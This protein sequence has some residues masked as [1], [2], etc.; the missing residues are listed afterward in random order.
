M[1]RLLL[2]LSIVIL[3]GQS[4][5]SG[6]EYDDKFECVLFQDGDQ[7][8]QL[9]ALPNRQGIDVQ[10]LADKHLPVTY[11]HEMG[12]VIRPPRNVKVL[13]LSILE[14][15]KKQ[16]LFTIDLSGTNA[17]DDDVGIL[18]TLPNLECLVLD[19]TNVTDACLEHLEKCK[20]LRLLSL[21]GCNVS[22]DQLKQ[23]QRSLPGLVRITGDGQTFVSI[24]NKN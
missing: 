14:I 22:N 18:S 3:I 13:K 23:L 21:H 5:T 15:S 20:K 7:S 19:S 12:L 10:S 8:V 1:L 6:M 11:V 2:L 16:T 17:T 4:I 24:R 9:W